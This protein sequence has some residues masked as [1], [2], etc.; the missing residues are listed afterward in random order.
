[1]KSLKESLVTAM[2]R[3]HVG[4]SGLRHRYSLS[5]LSDEKGAATVEY[6]LLIAVIVV[7]VIAAATYMF[8]PLKEFF[9]SVVD[10]IQGIADD[11]TAKSSF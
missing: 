3:M 9:L 4:W 8:D 10:K 2:Q 6:A 5:R 7:M 1:M 11:K